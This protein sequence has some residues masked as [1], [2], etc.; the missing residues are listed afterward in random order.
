PLVEGGVGGHDLLEGSETAGEAVAFAAQSFG[1]ALAL[2]DAPPALGTALH[3]LLPL[4]GQVRHE[5]VGGL[6]TRA[7]IGPQRFE[8]TPVA[9]QL[10]DLGREL[11]EVGRR[12]LRVAR[13]RRPPVLQRGQPAQQRDLALA[14][15]LLVR[16]RLALLRRRRLRRLVGAAR[17]LLRLRQARAQPG[18]LLAPRRPLGGERAHAPLQLFGLARL[19]G[20][21]PLRFLDLLA[22]I[23]AAALVAVDR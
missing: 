13:H 23:A 5:V 12:P 7:R 11:H 17:L 21:A 15:G 19:A 3:R 8:A 2:R 10:L 4:G 6:L 22:A 1:L 9:L 20:A 16:F 18:L 14:G